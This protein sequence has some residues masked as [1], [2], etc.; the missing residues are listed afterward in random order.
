[1]NDGGEVFF[2]DERIPVEQALR[3]VTIDAA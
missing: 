3:G 1:M 2:P